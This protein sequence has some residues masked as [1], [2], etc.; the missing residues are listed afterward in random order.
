MLNKTRFLYHIYGKVYGWEWDR[1]VAYYYFIGWQHWAFGISFWPPGPNIEFHLPF[2]FIRV[3]VPGR[4]RQ[5]RIGVDGWRQ[6]A[7]DN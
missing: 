3:G 2:G 1:F 6:Y 7:K 4:W 5:G